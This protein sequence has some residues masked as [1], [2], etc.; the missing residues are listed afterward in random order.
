MSSSQSITGAGHPIK[1]AA[2][3]GKDIEL[4]M[5]P[6]SDKEITELDSWVQSV[7]IDNARRSLPPNASQ[8]DIELTM[9]AALITSMGLTAFGGA[10]ARL[11]ATPRGVARLVWQSCRKNHPTLTPE[12]L[13]EYMFNPVNIN[14]ANSI[15]RKLNIPE[16]KPNAG[17][18][19]GKIPAGK[20]RL[21]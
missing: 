16:T 5:T 17:P 11:M 8:R 2:P 9:N 4:I 21:K 13:T 3:D 19:R 20:R 10:G 12:Q 18:Q 7:V 1:F 6:L 14:Q 15:F